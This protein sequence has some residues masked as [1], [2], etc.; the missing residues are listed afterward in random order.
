LWISA[1]EGTDVGDQMKSAERTDTGSRQKIG[2]YRVTR[3]IGKGG[4]GMVYLGIDEALERE[5]AVK[6]LNVEGT[7]DPEYRR[8]FEVEAKAAAKL[9]HPNILTVF[10]LGEDRGVPFIAMELLPG[11]DLETLVRSNEPMPLREKLEIV[12]QVC[13]GLAYAHDHGVVHRDI[14]PSNIRLLDDG[15]AKIMD[16]GIAKL[17]GTNLTKSGMMVGTLHYMS[18]EQV[19]GAPLDGRSDVFSVGVIL[20]ELLT[21]KRPFL[22]EGATQVLYK[23]VHED[24]APLAVGVENLGTQLQAIIVRAL[25]KDVEHRYKGAG[26]MADDLAAALSCLPSSPPQPE[27]LE[28]VNLVRRLLKQGNLDESL[29]RLQSVLEKNPKSIEARRTLRAAVR[30]KARR[31]RPPE[32]EPDSFPELAATFQGSPTRLEPETVLQPTA[33]S[34]PSFLERSPERVRGLWVLSGLTLAAVLAGGFY[35]YRALRDRAQQASISPTVVGGGAV[36]RIPVRSKPVGAAVFVDG[37]GTGVVTDGELTL[38]RGKTEVVLSF[39]KEGF[40]D[41]TRKLMLPL[42]EGEAVGV[43]LSAAAAHVSVSSDPPGASVALDGESLTGVTP[44]E[45]AFKPESEHRLTLSMNGYALQDLRLVPGQVGADLKVT[46]RPQGP[47]GAVTVATSYP[48]DVLWKGKVLAKGQVSPR[49][50]LPAGRQVLA[51]VSPAYFLK[52]SLAV[53]VRGGESKVDAPGL[54]RISIRANPDNCQVFI[55]GLFV[56]YPP[57]M[58]KA[59]AEG[60][61]TVSFK[62]PDGT[63]RE[64]TKEVKVGNLAYVMGRKD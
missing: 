17:S 1:E 64:E 24:A 23:I 37:Q 45:V 3:R 16:F 19:R 49:V 27:E 26:A 60:T 52:T 15:T 58:D 18:P 31:Q 20:Y 62:W 29:S 48:V 28:T 47:E 40:H 33:P 11:V 59:V 30:E 43:T 46:L 25:A 6:T 7:L 10:E 44:M 42:K 14:K 61:H 38:P 55:D 13:R 4:M 53:D 54:G 35:L 8:R 9:Q 22:G 39:R 5:V 36:V 2:R 50:S 51:L 63:Q 41:E 12:T 56:D 57:I 21:G 34:A 32:P